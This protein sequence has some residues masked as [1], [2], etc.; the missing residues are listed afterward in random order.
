MRL[1]K[2]MLFAVAGAVL[3]GGIV[4]GGGFLIAMLLGPDWGSA[5]GM[6]VPMVLTPTAAL[7]GAIVG[8]IKGWRS[9]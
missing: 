4:F 9:A 3:L 7:I 8:A 5:L 2:A 6:L 1:L